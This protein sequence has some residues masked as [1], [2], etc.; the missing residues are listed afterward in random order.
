MRDLD[1]NDYF[2]NDRESGHETTVKEIME[3]LRQ[4]KS[5][6]PDEVNTL[7]MELSSDRD[8]MGFKGSEV[9]KNKDRRGF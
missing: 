3:K 6:S 5:L 7:E 4:G 9:F 2:S 8:M 1:Y